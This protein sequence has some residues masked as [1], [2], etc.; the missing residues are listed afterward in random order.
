M[1]EVARTT[2]TVPRVMKRYLMLAVLYAFLICILPAS[3]QTMA[4]YNLSLIEYKLL[5]FGISIPTFMVW[6]AAFIGYAR[7]HD[8][9]NAIKGA[10]EAYG[11]K[12]LALGTT[13]L[14]WA[15]PISSIVAIILSGIAHSYQDFRPSSIIIANYVALLL[16]LI[17]FIYIGSAARA[18][19][20]TAHKAFDLSKAKTIITLFA[21]LGLTYCYFT[22]TRFDLVSL[23]N[24][25][26]PYY[27]PIWLMMFTIIVPYLFSWFT[28]MLAAL[29][30]MIFSKHVHGLLYRQALQLLAAGILTVVVSSIALQYINSASPR[31]GYLILGYKLLLITLFKLLAGAG[32]VLVAYGASKLK[33]IEEV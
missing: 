4:A 23:T 27:L 17:G 13:W 15:L 1:P 24:T 30:I 8:Y 6:L 5:L 10:P 12:R 18:L 7:F 28:G 20:A 22:F 33:R 16:P 14:A 26:N 9:A 11:Y 19:S 3:K 2:S 31:V 25:D 29:E 21:L 32:F